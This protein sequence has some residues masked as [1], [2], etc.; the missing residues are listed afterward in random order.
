MQHPS[1][2]SLSSCEWLEST[3]QSQLHQVGRLGSEGFK[4][5][6]E[7]ATKSWMSCTW[8]VWSWNSA[9]MLVF[10]PL[11]LFPHT[12]W[13]SIKC[14]LTVAVPPV[15]NKQSY[16][17]RSQI[18]LSPAAMGQDHWS[19]ACSRTTTKQFLLPLSYSKQYRPTGNSNSCSH[20][21]TMAS[22]MSWEQAEVRPF[23]YQFNT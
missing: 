5:Y 18:S 6:T 2:S 23:H 4:N 9:Y 17:Q 10:G 19:P 3:S 12:F 15:L 11:C 8:V 14:S 16:S 7:L 13:S 1:T 21:K 20:D 22:Y